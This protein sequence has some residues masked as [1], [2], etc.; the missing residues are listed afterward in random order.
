M[1]IFKHRGDIYISKSDYT[2]SSGET[3]ILMALLM[4]I[5]AV[6]LV[7]VVMLSQKYSSVAQFFADGKVTTSQVQNADDT[8][9]PKVSG[10][11]N[12][13]II[14]TDDN[15]K[16]VHYL[17]LL[18]A[19]KDNLAYKISV[20]SPKMDINGSTP[21][22]II[23]EGGGALLQ[24]KLAEYFGFEIDYY[25]QFETNKFVQFANKLGNFVYISP[26][27]I[28]Y[29]VKS[30][31]DAYALHISEGEQIIDGKQL[32]DL[33]RYYSNDDLNLTAANEAMLYAITELFNTENFNDCEAL[34][35]LF[36]HCSSTN[37]T[38]RDFE[39]GKDALQVFCYKNTDITIYSSTPQYDGDV[40]TQD[41]MQDIKGYFNK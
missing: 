4:V 2:K 17:Y 6:T 39:K 7:F 18:Q 12:Y 13:L 5:V 20:L 15:K 37:I 10:K 23:N 25:A 1:K 24:S 22:E 40:L 16:T 32:S 14:E 29:D 31:D 41:S 35:K 30:E 27:E 34:F 9:L 26:R 8:V 28:K 19:D 36:I 38:V 33:I 3:K 11:T 21:N